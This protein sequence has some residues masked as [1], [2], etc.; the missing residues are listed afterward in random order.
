MLCLKAV[1]FVFLWRRRTLLND[2]IGLN[3]MR[4]VKY[5]LSSRQLLW[6]VEVAWL[7][8]RST[9]A[10]TSTDDVLR[11]VMFVET[12]QVRVVCSHWDRGC[13]KTRATVIGAIWAILSCYFRWCKTIWSSRFA[14][15][16]WIKMIWVMSRFTYTADYMVFSQPRLRCHFLPRDAI[17]SANYAVAW[18][19]S[20]T[21]RFCVKTAKRIFKHYHRRVANHSSFLYQMLGQY[22]HGDHQR[23]RR[24][25]ESMKNSAFR[26][27]CRFILEIIQDRA[28]VTIKCE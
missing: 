28:T 14:L 11:P 9:T 1:G 15:S 19:P 5:M 6:S 13:S 18:C 10:L 17:H 12:E 16:C 23:G 26:R 21:G 7:V 22:S 20:V 4:M 25:Q 3:D 8:D 27:I 24:I 2:L